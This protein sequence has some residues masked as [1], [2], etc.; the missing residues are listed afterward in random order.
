MPTPTQNADDE[1]P[2][3]DVI[4]DDPAEATP[5]PDD[6]TLDDLDL[7]QSAVDSEEE[8]HG[9]P[10]HPA[11]EDDDDDVPDP[12]DDDDGAGDEGSDDG[13]PVG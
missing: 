2:Y 7:P 3:D 5:I 11:L 4:Q 8:P 13:S 10:E 12:D 6:G 1:G 9:E